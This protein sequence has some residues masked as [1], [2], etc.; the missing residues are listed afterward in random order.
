MSATTTA[1]TT[2]APLSPREEKLQKVRQALFAQGSL[3]PAII[4]HTSDFGGLTLKSRVADASSK[5][6][7]EGWKQGRDDTL[8]DL[9]QLEILAPF[10]GPLIVTPEPVGISVEESKLRWLNQMLHAHGSLPPAMIGYVRAPKG[11][12]GTFWPPARR[13]IAREH[14]KGEIA[15]AASCATAEGWNEGKTELLD[16][17]IR[18]N[19]L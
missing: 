19:I 5:A 14:A 12:I 2:A 17:L 16:D 18:L 8:K 3:P 9:I 15:E 7:S 6:R 10:R 4:C 11:M 1:T 13:E